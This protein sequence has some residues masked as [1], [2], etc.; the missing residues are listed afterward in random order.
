MWQQTQ[1]KLVGSGAVGNSTQG[2]TVRISANGT[3]IAVGGTGDAG[4]AG[5]VWIY[6]INSTGLYAQQGSKLTVSPA[7]VY[8]GGSIALSIDASTL[9]VG[10]ASDN[11]MVGALFVF[12]FNQGSYQQQG[13]HTDHSPAHAHTHTHTRA[14]VGRNECDGLCKCLTR[15]CSGDVR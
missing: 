14:Q 11:N 9:A 3:V 4:G 6:T 12:T 1:P 2:I 10:A 8:F 13:L 5:A 15:D 7:S